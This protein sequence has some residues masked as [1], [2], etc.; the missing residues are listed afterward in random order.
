MATDHPN[1]FRPG[2]NYSAF[3]GTPTPTAAAWSPP[4]ANPAPVPDENMITAYTEHVFGG[5][6]G[7][8]PARGYPE[9]DCSDEKNEL[10]WFGN[11]ASAPG[12]LANFARKV[13]AMRYSCFIVPGTV[14]ER[15]QALAVHVLKMLAAL[16][17]L[18]K[19]D[20][21]AKS[22]WLELHL[23][24]A[25]MVV[26]SGGATPEGQ[27]KLHLYWR[28]NAPAD[29]KRVANLRDV[30]ARKVAADRSFGSPHQPIRVA[31]SIHG[32]RAP[33]LVEIIHID[34]SRTLDLFALEE[35]AHQMAPL[36][37]LPPVAP[38]AERHEYPPVAITGDVTDANR[39]HGR[40]K[41]EKLASEFR[42]A[43]E[44]NRHATMMR[45]ACMLGG[46]V[47]LGWLPAEE[48]EN[49]FDDVVMAIHETNRHQGAFKSL[50]EGIAKGMATPGGPLEHDFR[51]N[52]TTAL[53]AAAQAAGATFNP[54]A[55]AENAPETFSFDDPVDIWGRFDPP[56]LPP[57][58]LPSLLERYA[59]AVAE[60]Q[61]SDMAGVAMAA[62]ATCANVIHPSISVQM[63]ENDEWREQIN[64]WLLLV[65]LPSTKKSPIM[66]AATRPLLKIEAKAQ[67]AHKIAMGSWTSRNAGM[68]KGEVTE[69]EPVRRRLLVDNATTEALQDIQVQTQGRLFSVQ[70][71]LAALLA[72]M[73]CYRT[74]GEFSKDRPYWLRAYDGG[75]YMIDRVRKGL[76][77][78][79]EHNQVGVLGGIQPDKIRELANSS[80]DDGLLQ[81][82]I[83]ITL[84]PAG[85]GAD[86]PA[87]FV[88]ARY[89]QLV[90]D[91]HGLS[92]P[93]LFDGFGPL[94]LGAEARA[95]REECERWVHELQ[96]VEITDA[97]LASHI[98]KYVAI[99]GRLCG[100]FHLIEETLARQT[101]PKGLLRRKISGDVARRVL[102]LI[103]TFILPHAAA[104]YRNT[105]ATSDIKAG[106]VE[107]VASAILAGTDDRI[108]PRDFRGTRLSVGDIRAA[109]RQL[110]GYGW[111]QAVEGVRSDSTPYLVNTVLRQKLAE[112]AEE[113]KARQ[114]KAA[115]VFAALRRT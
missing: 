9:A 79:I 42:N 73:D 89:S 64:L 29:P 26:R 67:D 97:K 96:A 57:G 18:D 82:F 53:L 111:V 4:M 32:K 59:R 93:F 77:N 85:V 31:G 56:E 5:M 76:G 66:K 103:K 33:R 83:C 23:G 86:R 58:I 15:G 71:E 49:C 94:Y 36:P 84:K 72:S 24:P 102:A 46:I 104:M 48:V 113:A 17:D 13:V 70:D 41:L 47:A 107:R 40:I 7:F 54:M 8:I 114:A 90:E 6:E 39:R 50:R 95:V 27:D 91:L 1:A 101:N 75:G 55:S 38:K 100:A 80:S 69:P 30:I 60:N 3:A 44:G 112:R 22:A 105:I 11:D 99:F 35:A 92:M 106:N 78:Y 109:L 34:K 65:G 87:G 108:L 61:G 110:E 14:A 21:A 74:G 43:D 115:A 28:L 52:S 51:T 45:N 63:K 19:G 81:R 16:V 20:I 88:S 10:D 68:K 12:Q 62:L 37:G 2:A 25:T 98:G